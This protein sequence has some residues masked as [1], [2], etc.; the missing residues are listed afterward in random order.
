[1]SQSIAEVIYAGAPRAPQQRWLLAGLLAVAMHVGVLI[2]ALE[3]EPTLEFWASDLATRV[4]HELSRLHEVPIEPTTHPHEPEPTPDVRPPTPEPRLPITNHR[5]PTTEPRQPTT[6]PAAAAEV[7]SAG[8]VPA[9]FTGSTIVTGTASVYAGGVTTSTGKSTTAVPPGSLVAKAPPPAPSSAKAIEPA[10]ADWG[11]PWPTEAERADVNEESATVRV[12]VGVDGV[13]VS[14]RV[15]RDPGFGFGSAAA[16]CAMRE[17]YNP[18]QD[19]AGRPI[20]AESAP[21]RVTF[22]R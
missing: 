20:R 21:I 18:A 19:D 10:N 13:P 15:L 7:I 16:A 5:Q 11:C 22:S 6:E 14:V 3:S 9:D 4:H 12:V 8:D 17:R 1:M 2:V